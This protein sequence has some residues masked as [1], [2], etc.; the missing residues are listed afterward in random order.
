MKASKISPAPSNKAVAIFRNKA[1]A[2]GGCFLVLLI[3]I[4]WFWLQNP[5]NDGYG[6][7]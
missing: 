4:I 2:F 1:F 7:T 6:Y 5:K 3:L